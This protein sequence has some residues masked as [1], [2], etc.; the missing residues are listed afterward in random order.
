MRKLRVLL[1]DDSSVFRDGLKILIDTQPDLTVTGSVQNT[2][3]ALSAAQRLKPDVVLI[4]LVA[5]ASD[6]LKAATDISSSQS[7]PAKVL[8]LSDGADETS[9]RRCQEAGLAGCLSKTATTDSLLMAIRE[10]GRGRCFFAPTDV[11][12]SQS[13]ASHAAAEGLHEATRRITTREA[14]V[15]KLIADGLVNKQIAAR[16]R[17]SIKT[18]EKHRQSLMNKLNIHSIALLTRYAIARHLVPVWDSLD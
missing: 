18:V 1:V 7:P 14:E 13:D 15:L 9:L 5:H 17:L 3:A 10:V 4:D 2:E 8:V 12:P 11:S 6:G 16:L